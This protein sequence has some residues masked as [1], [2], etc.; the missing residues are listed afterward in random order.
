MANE[1]DPHGP[2]C[3]TQAHT[4]THTHTHSHTLTHPHIHT[5]TSESRGD[6]AGQGNRE[7]DSE[8]KR[9]G[10]SAVDEINKKKK[11]LTERRTMTWRGN[12]ETKCV[13]MDYVNVNY[14][15]VNYVYLLFKDSQRFVYKLMCVCFCVCMYVHVCMLMCVC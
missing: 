6:T 15:N 7:K 14:V 13:L 10:K 1:I 2:L 4:Q 11:R 3:F 8:T 5:Q 9:D 12:T